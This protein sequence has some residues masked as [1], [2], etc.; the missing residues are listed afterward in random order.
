MGR[1]PSCSCH[2]V[3]PF[4]DCFGCLVASPTVLPT[5]VGLVAAG[6]SWLVPENSVTSEIVKCRPTFG[7]AFFAE[8]F[9]NTR[10]RPLSNINGS[11]QMR[12]NPT[13]ACR[14]LWNDLRAVS[15][16]WR[17]FQSILPPVLEETIYEPL[18]ATDS[19]SP[20]NRVILPNNDARCAF[21]SGGSLRCAASL[22]ATLVVDLQPKFIGPGTNPAYWIEVP[23]GTPGGA[24]HW[25][26]EVSV[27]IARSAINYFRPDLGIPVGFILPTDPA[28]G[29][30]TDAGK[31]TVVRSAM[32]TAYRVNDA[33]SGLGATP[34]YKY[35]SR[36]G[37]FGTGGLLASYTKPI[38][39]NNDFSGTPFNLTLHDRWLGNGFGFIADSRAALDATVPPTV[40]ITF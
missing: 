16:V 9:F 38:D 5:N 39:C 19:T 28:L 3:P 6:F 30:A 17:D 1:A 13:G 23:I 40:E 33:S 36:F 32:R 4:P 24:W 35:S 29:A 27:A 26:F 31:V 10:G 12:I 21:T 34:P 14:W 20:W 2:C 25:V 11:R 37:F 8:T 15:S 7:A 18:N 22:D